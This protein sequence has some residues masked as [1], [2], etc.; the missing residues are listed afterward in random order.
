MSPDPNTPLGTGFV[1]WNLAPDSRS[2][3]DADREIESD[4]V[5]ALT[6]INQHIEC[7]IKRG[8]RQFIRFEKRANVDICFP[9]D[10]CSLLQLQWPSEVVE[11]DSRNDAC[12]RS[13]MGPR[14]CPR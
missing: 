12:H 5:C 4:L 14:R 1:F 3:A 6:T 8:K 11:A 2:L 7:L 13:C 10:A 9:G